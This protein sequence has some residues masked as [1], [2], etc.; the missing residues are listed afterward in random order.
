MVV[1]KSPLCTNQYIL[2]CIELLIHYYYSTTYYTTLLVLLLCFVLLLHLKCPGIL[3]LVKILLS[4]L[5][6]LATYGMT[7]LFHLFFLSPL[8]V[9]EVLLD[10]FVDFKRPSLDSYRF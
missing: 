6:T 1:V 4:V 3:C 10:L 7:M 5:N 2:H 8:S 9:M